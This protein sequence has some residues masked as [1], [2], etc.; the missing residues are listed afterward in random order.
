MSEFTTS[1]I[2]IIV[3]VVISLAV[4]IY[5]AIKVQS[6]SEH[7]TSKVQSSS[8]HATPKVQ[9]SSERYNTPKVETNGNVVAAFS[10]Y[11]NYTDQNVMSIS[12]RYKGKTQKIG[13]RQFK[14][15]QIMDDSTIS[16][17]PYYVDGKSR[18]VVS[19][20]PLMNSISIE[21][22]LPLIPSTIQTGYISNMRLKDL[23][24]NK[25]YTVTTPGISDT[26]DIMFSH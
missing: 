24:L 26:F 9:S 14:S 18:I 4:S 7:A 2:T 19:D 16:E 20:K 23:V 12:L 8:K 6:S 15:L 11:Q 25:W 21:P 10:A 22:N 1:H 17:N 13:N 3:L 5:T